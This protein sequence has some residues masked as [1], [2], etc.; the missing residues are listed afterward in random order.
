MCFLGVGEIFGSLFNGR[1][2]DKMGPKKMVI[3][4]IVEMLIAFAVIIAFCFYQTWSIWF[5]C[6]FNFC[7][8]VQDAAVNVFILCI[9][10]F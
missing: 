1:L 2:E 7:W 10:G 4:N 8:G 3:L 5:A 9:C 6:L